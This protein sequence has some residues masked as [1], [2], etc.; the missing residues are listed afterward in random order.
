MT[1]D[2]LL[3]AH[4]LPGWPGKCEPVSI[5][6][7]LRVTFKRLETHSMP[8]DLLVRELKIMREIARQHNLEPLF[9]ELMRSTK[10]RVVKTKQVLGFV[11]T[12]SIRFDGSEI[13]INNI[14]DAA[15]AVPFINS[16]YNKVSW[17]SFLRLVKNEFAVLKRTRKYTTEMLPQIDEDCK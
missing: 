4:D 8:N 15:I 2:Y 10:R 3:T 12:N 16:F 5:E 9:N 11:L 13:G 1:A 14:F 7:L 6:N 17:S